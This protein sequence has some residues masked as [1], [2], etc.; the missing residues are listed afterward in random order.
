MPMLNHL[1]SQNDVRFDHDWDKT[2]FRLR[3]ASL[4]ALV[5]TVLIAAMLTLG[6]V[7]RNK[8]LAPGWDVRAAAGAAVAY[9]CFVSLMVVSKRKAGKQ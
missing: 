8:A 6:F 3:V 1:S 7:D 5:L 4:T 2:L 9:I